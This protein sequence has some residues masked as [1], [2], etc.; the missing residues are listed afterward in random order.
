MPYSVRFIDFWPGFN[1]EKFL[2]T[3]VLRNICGESL[4]LVKDKSLKVDLEITSVF[5]FK[6]TLNQVYRKSFSLMSSKAKWDY[7]SRAGRGFKFDYGSKAKKRIW[8]TGE[9][10][11]PPMFK[12]DG[13]ISFEPTS[14]SSSNLFFP[15][16]MLR[17]DWGFGKGEFEISP[18]ISEML[19]SRNPIKK[20]MKACSFSNRLETNRENLINLTNQFFEIDLFGSAH[21]KYVNSKLS[22]MENYALQICSENDLYPNYITEKIQESWHGRNVPIWSGLDTANWFNKSAMVDV[23]SLNA[24]EVKEK[25]SKLTLEEVMHKQSLPILNKAPNLKPLIEFLSDFVY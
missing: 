22:V 9:N 23:T 16:W 2:F 4:S 14:S 13:T 18:K 5:L 6:S 19:Q 12:F 11:R 20:E 15:Y 25:L 21:D 17:L 1:P 24:E 10:L 3:K 8:Y 7:L